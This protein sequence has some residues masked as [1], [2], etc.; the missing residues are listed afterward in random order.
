MLMCSPA[1]TDTLASPEDGCLCHGP[2]ARL[3][4]RRLQAGRS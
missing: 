2:T 1:E 3:V 4:A